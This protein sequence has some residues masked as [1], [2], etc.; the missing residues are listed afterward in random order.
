MGGQRAY[1]QLTRE[2][3]GGCKLTAAQTFAIAS[4]SA[5]GRVSD[6]VVGATIQ[7]LRNR[8]LMVNGSLSEK[9][10]LVRSKLKGLAV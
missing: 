1:V 2:D 4:A 3:V 7:H 5:A 8:G 6:S 10:L 9:G